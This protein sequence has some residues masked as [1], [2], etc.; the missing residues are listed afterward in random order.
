MLS[1]IKELRKSHGV[2]QLELA[3]L[4]NVSQGHISAIEQGFS[5]VDKSIL[6]VFRE[7][8]ADVENLEE[9]HERFMRAA[10]RE[11]RKSLKVA[12]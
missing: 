2:S 5:G 4:A 6:K 1:P 7:I 12:K 8:G 3:A 10:H 9:K 11:L